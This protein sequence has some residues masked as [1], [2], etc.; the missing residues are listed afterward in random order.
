MNPYFRIL[1]GQFNLPSHCYLLSLFTSMDYTYQKG[2]LLKQ[3]YQ[4]KAKQLIFLIKNMN[5]EAQTM[6]FKALKHIYML[7]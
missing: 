4:Q 2:K 3:N 5:I 1:L 6:N 7:C